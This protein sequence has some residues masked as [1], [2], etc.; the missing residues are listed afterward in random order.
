ML[1]LQHTGV[2]QA[3]AKCAAEIRKNNNYV[4]FILLPLYILQYIHKMY[5]LM[6]FLYYYQL[7]DNNMFLISF[8]Y[9]MII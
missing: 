5:Q 3:L 2:S 7:A 9:I 8:M 6:H 4:N 1:C